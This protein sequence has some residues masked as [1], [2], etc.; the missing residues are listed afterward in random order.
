M[1]I[2]IGPVEYAIIFSRLAEI[3]MGE[4]SYK[5]Q[6]IVIDNTMSE[7][8]QRQVLLHEIAH[9]LLRENQFDDEETGAE[10]LANAMLAL[11]Q[12][13]PYVIKWIGDTE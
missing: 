3:D 13:N 7:Q 12:K 9:V 11:I 4:V 1:T 2:T 6:T 5:S 10:A 8:L